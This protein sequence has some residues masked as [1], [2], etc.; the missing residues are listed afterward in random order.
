MQDCWHGRHRW[1]PSSS[2]LMWLMYFLDCSIIECN[3]NKWCNEGGKLILLLFST[4]NPNVM[5]TIYKQ[6]NNKYSVLF[7]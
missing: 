3:R 1:V 6:M 7:N 2:R 4:L 5:I